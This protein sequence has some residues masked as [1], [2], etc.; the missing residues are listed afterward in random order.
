VPDYLPAGTIWLSRHRPRSRRLVSQCPL[1]W[2]H[3]PAGR[4]T[5]HSAPS[6]C[7]A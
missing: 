4:T 1:G 5:W 7:D 3:A 2:P 6:A